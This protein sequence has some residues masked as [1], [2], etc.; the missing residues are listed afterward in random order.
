MK[1]LHTSDWHLGCTFGDLKRYEEHQSFLN[2]L[3]ELIVEEDVSVLLVAGDVFDNGTPSNQSKQQYYQFLG[4]LLASPCR[5]VVI[6]GGNHD[7]PTNLNAPRDVL[8]YLN[9]HV[10]GSV[11]STIEEE[12]LLLDDDAGNPALIVCA[13]SPV[14][15]GSR[16]ENH[17]AQRGHRR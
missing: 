15:E 2:W 8:K 13:R 9:I 11:E 17:R 10:V 4:R 6:T 3:V 7:S 12:V 5:H 16:R 14:P 1:V